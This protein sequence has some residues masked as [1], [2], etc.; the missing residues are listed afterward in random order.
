MTTIR[1]LMQIH[2][3]GKYRNAAKV[4]ADLAPYTHSYMEGEKIIYL[5]K[6]G[7]KL[8]GSTR[9]VKRSPLT[10][11][12][13]LCN[14]AYIYFRCPLDWKTEYVLEHNEK[15]SMS[16][17]AIKIGISV[18][19]ATVKK[20]IIADAAFSRNGYL[21]LVEIDN[22]RDMQDNRKKI[23]KY[24]EIIRVKKITNAKIYFFTATENRKEKLQKWLQGLNAHVL[25]FAEIK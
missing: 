2:D 15:A 21:H 18:K 1:Q 17:L 8:I 3:L 11:H 9:E 13:L 23:E 25:T 6:E 12:M 24:Q 19:S 4:V 7:R 10:V 14:E 16:G 5:N 20:K 22:T